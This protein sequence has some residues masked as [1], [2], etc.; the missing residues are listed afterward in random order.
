MRVK[1]FPITDGETFCP[2]GVRGRLVNA[3]VCITATLSNFIACQ[4]L[5]ATLDRLVAGR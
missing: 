3:S 5:R 1:F 4:V 2:H